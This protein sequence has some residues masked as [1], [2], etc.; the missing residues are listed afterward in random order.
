MQKI[1]QK[2]VRRGETQAPEVIKITWVFIFFQT[3]PQTHASSYIFLF[4]W[5]CMALRFFRKLRLS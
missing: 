5:N 1:K 3:W 4:I 2:K